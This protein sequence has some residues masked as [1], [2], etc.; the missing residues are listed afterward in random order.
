MIFKFLGPLSISAKKAAFRRR[1]AA[2]LGFILRGPLFLKKNLKKF[3][4]VSNLL[5]SSNDCGGIGSIKR[6]M[7]IQLSF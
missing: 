3:Y 2:F 6:T 4:K 7:L 1:N 5:F